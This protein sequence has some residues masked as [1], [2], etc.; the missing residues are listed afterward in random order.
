MKKIN[1]RGFTLV[2]MMLAIAITL[3]ISG[4]FV[5]LLVSIRSSYYRTYND[6]DCTDIAKM[7]AQAL[8]NAVLYSAQHGTADVIQIDTNSILT[9]T[10]SACPITF[11]TVPGFNNYDGSNANSLKWD[12]RMVCNYDPT[13]SEFRYKFYF[14]DKYVNPGYLHYT[15]EGSFWIPVYSAYQ[16]H[17]VG[18]GDT[19]SPSDTGA[20]SWDYNYGVSSYGFPITFDNEGSI[21]NGELVGSTMVSDPNGGYYTRLNN[22]SN[23][24]MVVDSSSTTST[25]PSASTVIH[26]AVRTD[27]T[28]T[29]PYEPA[30]TTDPDA[31]TPSASTPAPS[32]DSD[33]GEHIGGS[34]PAATTPSADTPTPAVASSSRITVN[35]P[36]GYEYVINDDGSIFVHDNYNGYIITC[37]ANGEVIV[38]S[39]NGDG[40][41]IYNENVHHS[42]IAAANSFISHG[43]SIVSITTPSPTP[44][45]TP[46]PTPIG[47]V[48][49]SYT[50]S[51]MY[52][53]SSGGN[54]KINVTNNSGTTLTSG[55]YNIVVTFTENVTVGGN[56]N[57]VS[58]NGTRQVTIAPIYDE[59]LNNGSP[60]QFYITTSYAN[61]ANVSI[62]NVTIVP[63]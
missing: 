28:A 59:T 2:E 29:D 31:T 50:L 36:A 62:A 35:V 61:G 46:L 40:S 30:P 45:P 4:L 12:I 25:V 38:T 53:G 1:K 43:I 42:S 54:G 44:S 20:W 57:V 18:S 34:T 13:T 23:G 55:N 47:G 26:I 14:I 16:S 32:S 41:N 6:D 3:L 48:A 49:T 37:N 52:F 58:G 15:Y 56:V 5:S 7:Y 22:T 24:N 11:N 63:T 33:E 17:I 21:V 60:T 19:F 9:N 51:D 27:A 10:N 8:E 39:T